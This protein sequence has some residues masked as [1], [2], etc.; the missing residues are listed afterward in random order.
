MRG[1]QLDLA[2]DAVLREA[3]SKR[4]SALTADMKERDKEDRRREKDR[5]RATKQERKRKMRDQRGE[6][7]NQ[8]GAPVL[9]SRDEE[10]LSES[11]G[12]APV[13]DIQDDSRGRKQAKT[14]TTTASVEDLVMNLIKNRA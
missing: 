10:E 12:E 1:L 5:L 9:L 7:D 4:F 2:D 11:D 14:K 3:A 6:D 8:A 13:P